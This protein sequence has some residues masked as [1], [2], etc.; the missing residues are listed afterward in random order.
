MNPRHVAMRAIRA[1]RLKELADR[2]YK[3][4]ESGQKKP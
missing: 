2:G 1:E 4:P 3:M